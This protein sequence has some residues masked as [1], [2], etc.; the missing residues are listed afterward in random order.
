MKKILIAVLLSLWLP[1][2]SIAGDQDTNL[3]R[4]EL[5]G[6]KILIASPTN[7]NKNL[8][9]LAHG[10]R[11]E[12]EALHADFPYDSMFFKTLLNEGWLVASTSYRRNGII[13]DDAITDLGYLRDYVIGKYGKPEKIIVKGSSMGGA[14][15]LWI[16]EN[17]PDW[18]DGILCE[19]PAVG[20]PQLKVK[21]THKPLIPLLFFANQNEAPRVREYM[22]KLD[23]EATRPGLWVVKR[24]GHG[25]VNDDETLLAF[26]EII[27]YSE[28]KPIQFT[29]EFLVD[30]GGRGS[31]AIF[32]E[33]RA[34]AMVTGFSPAYGNIYTL[35]V[36]SDLD[37][38]GVRKGDMFTVGFGEKEFPVKLGADYGDVPRGDW[39]AYFDARDGN[40][41]KIA[42][43]FANA[44]ETLECRPGNTI[45]IRK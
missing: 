40:A 37:R 14:I 18:A 4:A 25:N 44:A 41:L 31:V 45:Y 19:W 35:F 3:H 20:I 27:A 29:R 21:V 6:S 13:I 30:K 12:R 32:R 39:I 28:S 23:K 10:H 42:R 8:L 34:S 43:S 9:I 17:R 11:S 15:V 38:L 5:K 33:N 7:W 36:A 26:R 2:S 1:P 16:A 22:E 24:D